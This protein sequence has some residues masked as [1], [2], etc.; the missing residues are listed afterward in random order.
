M[1]QRKK[2]NSYLYG[3]YKLFFSED[4][5]EVIRIDCSIASIPPF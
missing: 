4:G 5:F 2:D 1:N 3:G